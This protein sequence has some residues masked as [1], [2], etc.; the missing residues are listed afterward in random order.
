VAAARLVLAH[1]DYGP[2]QELGIKEQRLRAAFD[3]EDLGEWT[4]LLQ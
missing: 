3:N 4:G 2:P 1:L